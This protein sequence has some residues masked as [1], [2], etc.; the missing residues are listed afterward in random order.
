MSDGW[1]YY[2]R[3][4]N[5][6]GHELWRQRKGQEGGERF[7]RAEDI[8]GACDTEDFSFLFRATNDD[9]GIAAQCSGRSRLEL[10]KYSLKR[11]DFTHIASTPFLGG[12]ALDPG[13]ATGYVELFTGCGTAIKPIRDGVVGEFTE[14]IT[15]AGK[16]W[17]LSGKQQDC[18]SVAESKS[19]VLAPDGSVFFLTAP[20]SI[21]KLPITDPDTEDNLE[22]YLCSWDG[23]STTARV[24]TKFP[25][26]VYVAVS[27]DGRFVF[28]TVGT[29][30]GGVLR[31]DATTGK[32]VKIIKGQ[33]IY[34]PSFSPDGNHLAYVSD[35]GHIRFASL[36]SATS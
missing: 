36:P 25:D 2:L 34:Q 9:L 8:V 21:G 19:P 1:V 4:V 28:A 24:V 11:K 23:H 22:W 33:Q 12:A 31:I 6:E 20:G 30:G 17:L 5:S 15:V 10:T 26:L 7:L 35:M 16:S 27:P 13:T 14:P 3:E 32:T 18:K 29:G